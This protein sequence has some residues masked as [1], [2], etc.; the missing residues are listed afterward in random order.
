MKLQSRVLLL[1]FLIALLVLVLIG[2]VL[3]SSLHKQNLNTV[4]GHYIDQLQHIDFAIS[5]FHLRCEV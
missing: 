5:N 1:Y 3:P 4:S 2:G